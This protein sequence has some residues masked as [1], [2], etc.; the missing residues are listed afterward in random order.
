MQQLD[1]YVLE[2]ICH[3]LLVPRLFL[4]IFENHVL[5]GFRNP[6]AEKFL[7]V[8]PPEKLISLNP[9]G[10]VQPL[11]VLHCRVLDLSFDVIYFGHSFLL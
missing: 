7:L 1:V 4:C 5:P 11:K 9:W 3:R 2:Y 8:H 10:D 6:S